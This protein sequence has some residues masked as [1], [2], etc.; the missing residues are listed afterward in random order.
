MTDF[1]TLELNKE[2]GDMDAE[3]ARDTLSEFMDA[4]KSNEDAYDA[5]QTEKEETV[6]EYEEKIED[7]EDLISEF[8]ERRAEKAAEYV[9][10][11]EDLLAKR[12]NIDELDQIIEEAEVSG[13]FTEEEEA[14][15]GETEEDDTLT[16]FSDKPER[17]RRESSGTGR[18]TRQRAEAKLKQHW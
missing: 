7:Y 3:E 9:E 15:E 5:L 6:S 16:T 10:M 11:P 1:T 18:A 17:G 8:R 13:E 4:H 14:D 2:I 12:F